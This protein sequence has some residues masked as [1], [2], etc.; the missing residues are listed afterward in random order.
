MRYLT[1]SRGSEWIHLPCLLLLAQSLAQN[2]S[3]NNLTSKVKKKVYTGQLVYLPWTM[4]SFKWPELE[5]EHG[6]SIVQLIAPP[7]TWNT[8]SV[9][10]TQ[11][12]KWALKGSGTGRVGSFAFK[13]EKTWTNTW[14]WKE[15][16]AGTILECV[17]GLHFMTSD[18][19]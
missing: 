6:V 7:E 17:I 16:H 15:F 5:A 19:H 1:Y 2:L 12:E 4:T 8:F 10:L 14:M 3:P 9:L 18:F 11:V 13:C